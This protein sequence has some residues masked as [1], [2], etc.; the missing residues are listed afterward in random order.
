MREPIKFEQPRCA[1]VGTDLFFP[2]KGEGVSSAKS[3]C[4][5]CIHKD[6]CLEWSLHH[7]IYGIW[8]G[9]TER[10]RRV[11]RRQRNIK[12]KEVVDFA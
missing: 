6:E 2:E 4:G 7:E 10:E 11:I 5:A 9:F 8:G 12:F 1:E 3:I